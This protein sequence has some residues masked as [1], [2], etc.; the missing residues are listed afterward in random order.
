MSFHLRDRL[1]CLWEDPGLLN[2]SHQKVEDNIAVNK[3]D[4]PEIMKGFEMAIELS[5]AIG[6]EVRQ[7]SAIYQC[8]RAVCDCACLQ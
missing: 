5:T 8:L 6:D 2:S 3:L 7:C 4:I 1:L